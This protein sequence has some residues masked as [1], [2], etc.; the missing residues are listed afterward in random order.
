MFNLS[1]FAFEFSSSSSVC[2][3]CYCCSVFLFCSLSQFSL[4]PFNFVAATVVV[5][6]LYIDFF[7]ILVYITRVHLF[8]Y[9]CCWS[10]CNSF[11]QSL[12]I[13]SI[14]RSVVRPSAHL[15]MCICFSWYLPHN[16][17]HREKK[18]RQQKSIHPHS[19]NPG[20]MPNG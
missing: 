4:F 2:Y 1:H 14:A 7:F 13:H 20:K 6:F 5:A 8:V 19:V 15:C 17:V 10:V 9:C 16:L 18:L 12:F 11:S 3:R